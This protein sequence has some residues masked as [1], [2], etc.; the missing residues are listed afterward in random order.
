MNLKG[1]RLKPIDLSKAKTIEVTAKDELSGIKKCRASIDGKWVLCEFETKKNLLFYSFDEFI[2]P[3]IHS[4]K[5][6]VRDDKNNLSVLQ[7]TF[8]R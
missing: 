8:N 2:T 1:D 3:G 7:F 6:E 5:L 4:F